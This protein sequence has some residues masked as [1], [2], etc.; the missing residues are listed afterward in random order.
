M[1]HPPTLLAV[2]A[3][4][5][6]FV[7][8]EALYALLVR[9]GQRPRTAWTYHLWVL[10]I[11]CTTTLTL[12][13]DLGSQ[14]WRLSASVAALLTAVVTVSLVD[15]LLIQRPWAPTKGPALPKLALDVLRA[16][17]VVATGLLVARSIL[18]YPLPAV[19][20]SST[21]LSAV[22]GLALQDVLKNVFA[23]MALEL[24]K[25]FSRGDWLLLDGSPVQVLDTSWRSVRLRSNEGVEFWEPNANLSTSRLVNYGSGVSP[26]ALNFHVGLP[27]EAPPAQVKRVLES[28]ARSIPGRLDSHPPTA[29]VD[30]YEESSI[31]YK[32]R[33]WTQD[34]AGL[35]QFK[36]S[37]YSRIWYELSRRNLHVP[38]PVRTVQLQRT[39]TDRGVQRE[40]K[41]R[42]HRRLLKSLALFRDLE[43]ETIDR[44]ANS[45][46][47][48]PYD[49]G[50]ILFREG[51][52]GDS[53]FVVAEGKVL[54]SKSGHN[55][56]TGEIPLASLGAGDFFGEMS[57]LTG[58]PRSA[59]VRADGPCD[60]LVLAQRHLAPLLE[61]QPEL[62]EVLSRAV[63]ERQARTEAT[64]EDRRDRTA[65]EDL[66]E[67]SEHSILGKIRTFFKLAHD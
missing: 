41:A 55:L 59:T 44:I 18:D 57:L 2:S 65:T 47:R 67:G 51:D 30:H 63:V 10:A 43:K 21:V 50:E 1:P 66:A 39:P 7:V 48:V 24:E 33:V 53:L 28:A 52:S 42:D 26:V 27:Y 36:D 17:A 20:V 19:L 4:F 49:D 62:A 35:S 32:L 23:G 40:R 46:R 9:L 16:V 64:V 13:D 61:E 5:G 15:S 34:V 14:A 38:Y 6:V 29:F 25:P 8:L 12:R 22:V 11:A 54:V 31:D 37:V 58:E 60:V 45:A 3:G 56:G